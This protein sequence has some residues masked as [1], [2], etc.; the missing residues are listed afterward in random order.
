MNFINVSFKSSW[1]AS[2]SMPEI[3]EA[4]PYKD[5]NDYKALTSGGYRARSRLLVPPC[6][7][8]IVDQHFARIVLPQLSSFFH[9]S[10]GQLYQVHVV[11]LLLSIMDLFHGFFSPVSTEAIKASKPQALLVSGEVYTLY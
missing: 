10:R 11:S 1:L 9:A 7:L 4:C 6:P 5:L 8:H 2:K 3:N